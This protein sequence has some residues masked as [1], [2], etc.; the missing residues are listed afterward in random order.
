MASK[1]LS[2]DCSDETYMHLL[3]IAPHYAFPHNQWQIQQP[4][5]RNNAFFLFLVG[6]LEEEL[7]PEFE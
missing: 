2:S 6:G 5:N 4:K 3:I 1:F 7:I